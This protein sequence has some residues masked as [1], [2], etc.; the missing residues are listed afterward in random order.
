[1]TTLVNKDTY[2][3]KNTEVWNFLIYLFFLIFF[4]LFY[5]FL[6]GGARNCLYPPPLGSATAC[7]AQVF[8]YSASLESNGASLNPDDDQ[9]KRKVFKYQTITLSF[10]KKITRW[11]VWV[12][13]AIL[14]S[15]ITQYNCNKTSWV[16]QTIQVSV[17]SV[18]LNRDVLDPLSYWTQQNIG[19]VRR[20]RIDRYYIDRIEHSPGG[21]MHPAVN[22]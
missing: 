20:S 12:T 7:V 2:R 4:I 8:L 10:D 11:I 17:M 3:H 21:W 18:L 16:I 19:C 1:M 13:N 6:G 14:P 9:V 22:Q 5:F 15:N